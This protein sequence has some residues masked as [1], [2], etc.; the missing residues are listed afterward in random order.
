MSD[1]FHDALDALGLVDAEAPEPKQFAPVTVISP[2][3]HALVVDHRSA[4]AQ[5]ARRAGFLA[6]LIPLAE[7]LHDDSVEAREVIARLRAEQN[8]WRLSQ[9]SAGG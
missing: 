3:G 5:A 6:R 2:R 1:G 4:E 8:E 7:G 9:Q